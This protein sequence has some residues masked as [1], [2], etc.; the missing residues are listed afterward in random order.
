M[1]E[2]CLNSVAFLEEEEQLV[3]GSVCMCA[4]VRERECVCV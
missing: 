2:R 4:C 3:S 1:L